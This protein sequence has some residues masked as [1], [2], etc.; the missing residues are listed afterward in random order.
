[1]GTADAVVP[2]LSQFKAH[3][4]AQA[5]AAENASA[6]SH[7]DIQNPQFCPFASEASLVL[8]RYFL[9]IVRNTAVCNRITDF[10]T[11]PIKIVY[12]WIEQTVNGSNCS[13]IKWN[14]GRLRVK[15]LLIW[16][17]DSSTSFSSSP[18]SLKSLLAKNETELTT[19]LWWQGWWSLQTLACLGGVWRAKS[20]AIRNPGRKK[21]VFY[22][23]KSL[24]KCIL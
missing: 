16:H 2:Q 19:P 8:S 21:N 22:V 6:E 15:H 12:H 9:Q 18:P 7:R 1:M 4:P 14:R 20:K 17:S 24:G 23:A 11:L 5:I 10:W 3:I 13:L